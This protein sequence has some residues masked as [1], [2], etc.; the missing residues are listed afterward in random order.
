MTILQ[1][2][3]NELNEI[4]QT[5]LYSYSLAMIRQNFYLIFFG[6]YLKSESYSANSTPH[7]D[8]IR[9]QILYL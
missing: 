5:A 3:C 8:Q 7:S 9:R 1:V 4:F 6:L 2:F